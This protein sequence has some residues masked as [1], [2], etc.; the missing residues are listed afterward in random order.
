MKTRNL[1]V[2]LLVTACLLGCGSNKPKH[3]SRDNSE[4]PRFTNPL[5][6][7][8]ADPWVTSHNRMYYITHSTGNS[9]KLYRTGAVSQLVQAESKIVWTPPATG[10]NS[11]EI[12]APEIHRVNGKWYFY[13]AADD[14]DN[15][16]H[17]MWVL[18]NSSEDPFE[19]TWIDKGKMELPDDKWAIDGTIFEHNGSL[20]FMWSGWEG[21]VNVRQDIYITR[22]SN[23][24]TPQG[25]RV[26]LSK[27]ELDWEIKG[28]SADLP[29]INEGPQFLKHDNSVFI[30][31]SA[32]GCWTDDYSLGMLQ[33]DSNAD[34]M[35]VTSWVKS[36]LPVFQKNPDG[37]AFGPGHNSF[38]QSPDG[39]E[40][41]IIYHA[42]PEPG[43]GCN[44]FRS[45]RMQ[46]FTWSND[47]RPYFGTPAPVGKAMAIPSGE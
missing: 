29:T 18:E 10:M 25:N 33:A 15:N 6:P 8:G 1:S 46:P 30:I 27:P 14:G 32:S 45:P 13:Y 22:M 44:A 9:L 20:Y 34:L 26:R 5:L 21:D 23:P 28:A 42:N 38:F 17:R 3:N 4:R 19:G 40:D 47:G 7:S 2:I 36:P 37:E 11:K 31:Y 35:A 24:W 39:K 12:W 43:Q 41:W 16:H